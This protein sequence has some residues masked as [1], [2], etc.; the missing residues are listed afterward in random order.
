M[1][2]QSTACT[3]ERE[4]SAADMLFTASAAIQSCVLNTAAAA[5]AAAAASGRSK[6]CLAGARMHAR[7]PLQAGARWR[8]A[9]RA[10][11]GLGLEKGGAINQA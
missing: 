7:P 6:M 5:A 10:C 11:G 3:I 8:T 9:P 2:L 1:L 4:R